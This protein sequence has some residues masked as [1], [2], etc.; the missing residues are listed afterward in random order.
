MFN[1]GHH[2]RNCGYLVCAKCSAKTWPSSMLPATFHNRE[3]I[4]RVC[5]SC[6]HLVALFCVALKR[7]DFNLALSVYFSGNVNLHCPIT[8]GGITVHPVHLAARGGNLNI[9]R[10]LIDGKKCSIF[11]F[12]DKADK[13]NSAPVPIK[14]SSGMTVLSVSEVDWSGLK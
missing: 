9:L 5:N 14:T 1:V 8:V 7:G 3:T 4:V 2:C 11:E 6:E 12:P 13:K 10:W